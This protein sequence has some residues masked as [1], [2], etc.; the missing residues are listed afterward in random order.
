M[1]EVYIT[2]QIAVERYSRRSNGIMGELETQMLELINKELDIHLFISED[3]TTMQTKI[4]DKLRVKFVTKNGKYDKKLELDFL[5]QLGK[6]AVEAKV[7][8]ENKK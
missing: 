4:L 1:Q 5:V 7:R 6:E 3:L 8:I 2:K